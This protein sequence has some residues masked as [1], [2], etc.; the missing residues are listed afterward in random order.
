LSAVVRRNEFE[1]WWRKGFIDWNLWAMRPFRF[2]DLKNAILSGFLS[3]LG[4][5]D[6]LMIDKPAIQ[7]CHTRK[8]TF[9]GIVVAKPPDWRRRNG[10][11]NGPNAG[12][13]ASRIEQEMTRMK[14][15]ESDL[16]PCDSASPI[17]D[18]QQLTGRVK[19][20]AERY[21]RPLPKLA[22]RVSE[23]EAK[24]NAHLERMGFIWT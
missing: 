6:P 18:N 15:S 24:V 13:A 14:R 19:E 4:V 8:D 20:L 2:A 10:R 9:I 3:W 5:V 17:R 11:G 12:D 16:P 1:N 23:L 22:E 7:A 21:D